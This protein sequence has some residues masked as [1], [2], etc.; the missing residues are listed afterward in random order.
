MT[1]KLDNFIHD[2]EI[3]HNIDSFPVMDLQKLEFKIPQT[4]LYLET[5][6]KFGKPE[7]S[8]S[9]YVFNP[10]MS[11]KEYFNLNIA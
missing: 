1:D 11:D 7:E 10:L 3:L 6:A 5:I 9:S 8:L 2:L 4:Y